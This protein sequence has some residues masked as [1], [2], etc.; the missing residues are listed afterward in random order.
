ML[1]G[2]TYAMR[3]SL[4]IIRELNVPIGEIR[5]S[6][7]GAKSP[8]WRQLQADI[9]HEPCAVTNAA[10]GP[11]YGAALLAMAGTG[12]YASVE[13]ACDATIE[14]ADRVAPREKVAATYDALYPAYGRLYEALKPHFAATAG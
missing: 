10:E 5:L 3:D 8:F 11:A 7:G 12:E 14:V 13:A 9:Y 4:E 2:V 6:G 1:E